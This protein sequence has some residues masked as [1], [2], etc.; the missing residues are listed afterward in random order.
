MSG[1][2]EY[3]VDYFLNKFKDIPPELWCIKSYSR[4]AARCA[5]GHCR[6]AENFSLPTNESAALVRLFVR[7][8]VENPTEI[9]D[10]LVPVFPQKTPKERILAALEKIK[11]IVNKENE[12][13]T[14]IS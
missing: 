14:I 8:L 2:I 1:E 3:N 12:S 13:K 4:G 10:G 7:N 6:S 9:N 11:E 5:V